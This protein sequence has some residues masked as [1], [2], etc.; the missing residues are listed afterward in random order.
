MPAASPGVNFNTPISNKT[1]TNPYRETQIP[2]VPSLDW[3]LL[4]VIPSNARSISA[5]TRSIPASQEMPYALPQ[6]LQTRESY[7]DIFESIAIK[8]AEL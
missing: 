8:W 5:L 1:T 4:A 2:T 6:I 3:T 7:I